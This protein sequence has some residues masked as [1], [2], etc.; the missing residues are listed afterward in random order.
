MRDALLTRIFGIGLAAAV[1]ALTLVLAVTGQLALYISPDGAWFAV[2]MAVVLLVAAVASCTLPL[3]AEAEAHDHDHAPAPRRRTT[4]EA[5]H[6]HDAPGDHEHPL[7]E[8]EMDAA[9][10]R[11]RNRTARTPTAPRRD[12]RRTL[13]V[14]GGLAGG[15]LSVV[16]VA[17]GVLVPPATLSAELAMS[18]DT[19][20]PPLFAGADTVALASMGD[21]SAFGVGE[22]ASVFATATNPDAF[23]GTTVTLTGF[24]TPADGDG[25]RLT[26]LVVT[27]CVIDAQP[28]SVPILAAEVPDTGAWVEVTGTVRDRGGRLV[29]E[30]SELV[31]VDQ[32]D[33]PYE[34]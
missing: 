6:D 30:P 28:A 4:H 7:S 23:D 21:T 34:F 1:A 10:S 29:I 2:A 31:P 20:V 17:A 15:A 24:A 3:G 13:A 26:R 33:D 18:R 25:F 32:P 9:P 22:W 5:A 14:A 8:S 11:R 12:L 16:V 19:G 27:H